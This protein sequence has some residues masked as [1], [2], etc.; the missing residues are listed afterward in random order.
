[1]PIY[2]LR[3]VDSES[4]LK[5]SFLLQPCRKNASARD[6]FHYHRN[7]YLNSRESPKYGWSM[8]SKYSRFL[9]IMYFLPNL[10]NP[11]MYLALK[12]IDHYLNLILTLQYYWWVYYFEIDQ[13]FVIS[14]LCWWKYQLIHSFQNDH[15]FW[16]SKIR[17]HF[18]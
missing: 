8:L 2:I 9:K 16:D 3:K 18:L 6:Y 11:P 5:I 7:L 17:Q 1:L 12:F 13:Q 4:F 14:Y 10:C 15:F